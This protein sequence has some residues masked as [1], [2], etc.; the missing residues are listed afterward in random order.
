MKDSAMV[1]VLAL[2]LVE[3]SVDWMGETWAET[4][5]G[6]KVEWKVGLLVETSVVM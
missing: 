1:A 5:A 2:I 3:E 4:S 6:Q